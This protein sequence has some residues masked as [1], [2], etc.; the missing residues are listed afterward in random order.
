MSVRHFIDIDQFDHGQLR[1]IIDSAKKI[2][3]A[4]LDYPKSKQLRKND[5]LIMIFEKASTRTRVSFDVAMR[6]LGG[7]TIVLNREDMQLGRGETIADTARVLS[8]YGDIVMLRTVDH[9]QIQEFARHATVP[10]VNGLTDRSHPCQIMADI[11][12]FEEH[13]CPIEQ[14]TIAW[15]GDANN[16]S[17]SWVHAAV[18]FGFKLRLGSPAEFGP[19]DELL[20]W[21][22][23]ENG[24][25]VWFE[26]PQIAV[27]DAHCVVTDV[28][29][30]MGDT[31]EERRNL[32]LSDYVVDE[33]LMQQAS[34]D[35]I[36]MHCL[37]ANRGR[38]VVAEVID[39]PRSVVFDEAEN[40]LHAQKAILAW[41]LEMI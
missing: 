25:V 8:R 14:S 20:E 34:A 38:E 41:C 30:S 6:Q 1:T 13:K 10:V 7:Q 40:R 22:S 29:V 32:I 15:I 36:F 35:A 28:F 9:N 5:I 23:R 31:D 26:D 4:G 24:D 17:V 16:V 27:R 37:P 2:K 18:R 39:G 11:L 19:S 3:A 33:N 12:T 21:V